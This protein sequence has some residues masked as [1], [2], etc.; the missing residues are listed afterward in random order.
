MSILDKVSGLFSAGADTA[1]G[2]SSC[3]VD[4]ACLADTRNGQK[5]APRAKI[6]IMQRLAKIAQQEQYGM[7]VY[8]EGEALRKV[9]DGELFDE[10]VTVHYA[11][12]EDAMAAKIF[13][14]ARSKGATVVTANVDLEERLN[15]AGLNSIRPSTFKKGFDKFFA[16]RKRKPQNRKRRPNPNNNEDGQNKGQEDSSAPASVQHPDNDVNEL[17]DLVE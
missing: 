1:T 5:I 11:N 13:S 10:I 8:F 17:I 3:I 12:D 7:T 9:A 2:T 6:E 15:A 4:A 14:A 16:L